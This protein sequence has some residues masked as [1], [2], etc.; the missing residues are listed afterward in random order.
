MRY[1]RLEIISNNLSLATLSPHVTITHRDHILDVLTLARDKI[2][3][4]ARLVSHPLAGSVKPHETPYR[5]IVLLN[6]QDGLDMASLNTIEQAIERYQVLCK[7]NPNHMTLTA[8]D[9]H[10]LFPEKQN[11]DFQFIDLQLIKS[12][13][14]AMGVRFAEYQA[15]VV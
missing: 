10:R 1:D 8:A 5:S 13:L 9:I 2:H 3:T 11:R 7:P 4:G 14:S 15:A 12:S 6:Q